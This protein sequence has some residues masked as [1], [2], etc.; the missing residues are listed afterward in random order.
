MGRT[1]RSRSPRQRR[2]RSVINR[3]D[4]YKHFGF[5]EC[6]ELGQDALLSQRDMPSS[7]GNGDLVTFEVGGFASGGKPQAK[8]LMRVIDRDFYVGIVEKIS[9]NEYGIIDSASFQGLLDR[10]ILSK[11]RN[12]V[13]YT[14]RPYLTLRYTILC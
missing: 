2:F 10:Q 4:E 8:Q 3:Y 12:W 6:P 14:A 1:N 11:Q 5:I 7:L 13:T 9:V